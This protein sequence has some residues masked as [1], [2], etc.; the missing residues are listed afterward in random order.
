MNKI[1]K[2]GKVL[3][4]IDGFWQPSEIFKTLL[5][6][7]PKWWKNWNKGY[8]KATKS[9]I[10]KIYSEHIEKDV[11]FIFDGLIEKAK[12]YNQFVHPELLEKNKYREKLI[13]LQRLG[14]APAYSLLLFIFKFQRWRFYKSFWIFWKIGLSR[15]HITDYPATNKLDQIFIDLISKMNEQRL[16]FWGSWIIF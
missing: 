2:N 13:D 8:T 4:S 12:I 5:S 9:N 7:I 16:C 10:I 14:I 3:D 15:R 1:I 11:K 6:C